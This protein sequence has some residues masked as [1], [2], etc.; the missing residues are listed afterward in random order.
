[1][2]HSIR[3]KWVKSLPASVETRSAALAAV[4]RVLNIFGRATS[5][6]GMSVKGIG[7]R[8]LSTTWMTPLVAFWS[9][10]VTGLPSAVINCKRKTEI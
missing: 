5:S 7:N 4:T 1:M 3:L 6:P 10:T 9:G 8:T 2:E